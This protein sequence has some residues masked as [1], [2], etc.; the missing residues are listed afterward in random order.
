MKRAQRLA[1]LGAFLAATLAARA[2]PGFC[3]TVVLEPRSESLSA[4]CAEP[5]A[6][7]QDE[8]ACAPATDFSSPR[9][10]EPR[11]FLGRPRRRACAA[12]ALLAAASS[13]APPVLP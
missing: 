2:A 12:A 9:A 6:D 8:A 3:A 10:P 5:A 13:R 7:V 1:V 11:R 4:C